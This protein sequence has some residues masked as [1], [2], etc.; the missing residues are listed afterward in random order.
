L[1]LLGL[2]F[3]S[4]FVWFPK[5]AFIWDVLTFIGVSMLTLS[6]TKTV[7]RHSLSIYILHH[8]VH[9]W[10]LWIY[11]TWKQNEP[12]QFPGKAMSPI[13]SPLLAGVFMGGAGLLLQWIEQANR[14][15]NP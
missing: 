5:D 2:G 3:F 12:T 8:V 14:P 13:V 7:S 6:L 4:V 9:I 11:G 10:P 1:F 15:S